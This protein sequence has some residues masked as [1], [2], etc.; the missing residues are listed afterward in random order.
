MVAI[1]EV[2][3]YLFWKVEVLYMVRDGFLRRVQRSNT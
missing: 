3:L 1:S 2:D